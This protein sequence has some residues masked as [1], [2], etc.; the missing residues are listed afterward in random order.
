MRRIMGRRMAGRA[1]LIEMGL[2]VDV[3]EERDAGGG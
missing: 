3:C 1:K 2:M